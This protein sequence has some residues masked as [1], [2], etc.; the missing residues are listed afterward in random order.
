MQVKPTRAPQA[1]PEKEDFIINNAN[2]DQVTLMISIFALLPILLT[3]RLAL[4]CSA[5]SDLC[6]I[7]GE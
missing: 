5:K 2:F 1:A 3:K 6:R 4:V 7:G